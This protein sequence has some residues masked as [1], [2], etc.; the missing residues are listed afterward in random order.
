MTVLGLLAFFG[1]AAVTVDVLGGVLAATMLARGIRPRRL[2]IFLAGY[3][4]VVIPATL[5]LKPI[6]RLLG[7]VLAPVLGSG[8]WLAVIQLAIG[9]AL[10]AVAVY[11]RRSAARPPAP[12]AVRE[13]GDSTTSLLAGGALFSATILADPTYPVAVG[14]AMQA[15]SAVLEVLL[16]VAWNLVYQ[17][18]LVLVTTAALLGGHRLALEA[19]G[20][21][22]GPRRRRLLLVL[23]AVL[24]VGGAVVIGDA[25]VALCSEH[26]SWLHSL[27]MLRHRGAP[28]A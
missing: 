6:L 28:P 4:A 27:V 16:L 1:L 7:E 18:P 3:A 12:A 13:V 25:T 19:A 17:A 9:A 11:Q 5:V 15:G 21:F 23:S 20:R 14:M 22:F 26:R 8:T 24:A 10:L 2:L